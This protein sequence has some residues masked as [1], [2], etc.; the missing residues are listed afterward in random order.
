MVHGDVK[1][2][3]I[4]VSEDPE[5]PVISVTLTDF[6]FSCFADTE[7]D[8]VRL[9]APEWR[10]HQ[11]FALRDAKKL[12]MY[13]FGLLCMW[14]F[15]KDETL[16]QWG[17]TSAEVHTAFMDK[18]NHAFNDLQYNTHLMILCCSWPRHCSKVAAVCHQI[19]GSP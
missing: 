16:S 12:D 15:F 8:L 19:S 3:N 5:R 2:G 14:L 11:H 4:L 18:D 6:G 10:S 13:S 1:P 7:E 9:E 17:H